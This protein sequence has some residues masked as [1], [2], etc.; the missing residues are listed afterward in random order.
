[1]LTRMT[2]TARCPTCTLPLALRERPTGGQWTCAECGGIALFED[3]LRQRLTTTQTESLFGRF[4]TTD[5]EPGCP[6][7]R[8]ENSCVQAA[9]QGA[10]RVVHLD[11]C[12]DC[13]VVWF[14][15][16]ELYDFGS[17]G[18][19]ERARAV[20]DGRPRVHNEPDLVRADWIDRLAD[21]AGQAMDIAFDIILFLP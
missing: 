21:R 12:L 10:Q 11:A 19:R 16:G 18:L 7:P 3:D 15:A 5:V 17:P 20:D 13:R 4:Q 14:D 1:M 2:R 8:C 9:I 6:C